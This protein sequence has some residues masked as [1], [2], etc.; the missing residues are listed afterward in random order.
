MLNQTRAGSIAAIGLAAFLLGRDVRASDE[1]SRDHGSR[2]TRVDEASLKPLDYSAG[3]FGGAYAQGPAFGFLGQAKID[4]A[5][6]V[7]RHKFR[8]GTDYLHDPFSSK[9]FNFPEEDQDAARRA[10]L[11]QRMH[12]IEGRVS[13]RTQWVDTVR[14]EVG[15]RGDW[16][17]PEFRRDERWSFRPN[18][19]LKLGRSK[20]F[21][22]ELDTEFFYKKFPNYLVADRRIDQQ[23]V[24]ADLEVGYDF[25]KWAKLSVGF[26]WTFTDYLDA[27]Y[28]RPA[29]GG[30]LERAEVSK[31][32][33]SY[34]PYVSA[35]IK[36]T[37]GLR[38]RARYAIQ[39]HDSRYYDRSMSGRDPD[40]ALVQKFITDYYDYIR[41]RATLRVRWKTKTERFSI[42]GI[43]EY[44]HRGFRTYEAR[45]VDNRWLGELRVDQ[46]LEVGGEASVLAYG[47]GDDLLPQGL[48]VSAFGSHL[49][50][51]SNMKREVSLATNFQIT[52]V[53][54][55]LELR[56]R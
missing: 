28:D 51:T 21:F 19:G 52:R 37:K 23:G 45:A 42:E 18:M 6:K 9:T 35:T 34:Q 22:A 54:L 26:D 3:V 49:Y 24:D 29:P 10:R 32:Y 46:S 2:A 15:V 12:I 41:Q 55:G 30:G 11:V 5:P 38:V 50:R 14:T 44:W 7:E 47:F 53:F 1:Q 43:G 56:T 31:D 27:R 48:Y 16:W 13:W 39:L 36:P 25:K 33:L 8:V 17:I 40:G 20:G 4:Y